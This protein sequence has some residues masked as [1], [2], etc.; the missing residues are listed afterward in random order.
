MCGFEDNKTGIL[1]AFMNYDHQ[2][3]NVIL[4]RVSVYLTT[5]LFSVAHL[6]YILNE[7]CFF[8]IMKKKNILLDSTLLGRINNKVHMAFVSLWNF[9]ENILYIGVPD[10]IKKHKEQI[11]PYLLFERNK[12]LNIHILQGNS[13]NIGTVG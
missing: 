6:K 9:F 3:K 4:L 5:I 2:A 13:K 10:S 8:Q 7:H 1:S 12:F 11:F